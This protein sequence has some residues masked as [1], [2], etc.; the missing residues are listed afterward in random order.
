MSGPIVRAVAT[1]VKLQDLADRQRVGC[2]FHAYWSFY[3]L[4]GGKVLTHAHEEARR[5]DEAVQ[6]PRRARRIP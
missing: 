4:D 2:S 6:V 5:R 1:T 3:A